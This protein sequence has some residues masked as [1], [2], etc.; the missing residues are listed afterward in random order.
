MP[1]HLLGKKSWNVYNRDNVE[2]VRR[3]E[4]EAQARQEAED[5]RMQEADAARRIA[6]L[7]GEEPPPLPPDSAEVEDGPRASTGQRKRGAE[8][9]LGRKRKRLRGE[10]DTDRA[11]RYAREDAEAGENAR[12]TLQL[13]QDTRQNDTPLVDSDG[14]L[15]L[16]PAPDEAAVRK[17]EKNADAEAEKAK[18]KRRDEDQSTMRFSNAA[19][20]NTSMQQKPWYASS[21]NARIVSY[22]PGKDVWG[23]EDPRRQEREQNRVSTNDPFAA[24]QQAQRQ[25]KQ[26]VRDRDDWKRERDAEM[27]AMRR[28]EKMSRREKKRRHRQEVDNDVDSLDGFSL[29][30]WE[31]KREDSGRDRERRR[32]RHH[33][34]RK[35]RSRFT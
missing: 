7:R 31:R 27:L 15:Q 33:H 11:I 22:G 3:D 32:H 2:R 24:M 17:V 9:G 35:H 26:S 30:A 4:A 28:E 8:D 14:H 1:L 18:N 19:G 5:Q 16:I 13:K 6:I 12:Q 21:E 25:L 34:R 23:N 20:F 29:D 10:D